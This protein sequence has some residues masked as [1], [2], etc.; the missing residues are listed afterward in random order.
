MKKKIRKFLEKKKRRTG[1][2]FFRIFIFCF[3][4]WVRSFYFLVKI[5]PENKFF[6][7]W[8]FD[9][10]W[11]QITRVREREGENLD[12]S[13]FIFSHFFQEK[14]FPFFSKKSIHSLAA[15]EMKVKMFF[16]CVI[17]QH[18]WKLWIFFAVAEFPI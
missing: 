1:F 5:E 7:F 2:L 13:D 18:Q 10:Y 15:H 12:R 9:L 8:S 4:K 17:E 11:K 14:I 3:K 16:F 6:F